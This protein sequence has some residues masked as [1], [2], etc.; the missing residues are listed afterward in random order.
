RSRN[1]E[2]DRHVDAP[3]ALPS[4]ALAI[5]IFG[6]IEAQRNVK[7]ILRC[8]LLHHMAHFAVTDD[9]QIHNRLGISS[10][11]LILA[12]SKPLF[13]RTPPDP[14][15]EKITDAKVSPFSPHRD[16]QRV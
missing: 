7:T 3:K 5:F 13:T 8:Q 9:R 1:G 2:I 4:D 11:P 16:R 12:R 6:D 14:H 10:S 15:C